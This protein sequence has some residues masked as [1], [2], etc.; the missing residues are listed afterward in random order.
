MRI[1][2]WGG[3]EKFHLRIDIFRLR[4]RQFREKIKF[5][6]ILLNDIWNTFV[7]TSGSDILSK[8]YWY[9]NYINNSAEY[10]TQVQYYGQ[11]ILA[12]K[13]TIE[14][15]IDQN[16]P[17]SGFTNLFNVNSGKTDSVSFTANTDMV[18]GGLVP[19]GAQFW[20]QTE[21]GLE[22]YSILY[23]NMCPKGN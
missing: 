9:D 6:D 5:P 2:G 13:L 14:S 10:A 18:T 16:N 19:Y 20:A 1:D 11:L 8:A 4:Y 15:M 23:N 7:W 22:A 12:H 3:I 21:Y 17:Q